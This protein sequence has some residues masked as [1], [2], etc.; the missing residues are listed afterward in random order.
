[1]REMLRGEL[2]RELR[3]RPRSALQALGED[4]ARGLRASRG[5]SLGGCYLSAIRSAMGSYS[6]SC[7]R[8]PS[9]S[10]TSMSERVDRPPLERE[11][12]RIVLIVN[13]QIDGVV[14]DGRRAI[15]RAVG[16]GAVA[17]LE[18][19]FELL[20]QRRLGG[21]E[22]PR[23]S[24]RRETAAAPAGGRSSS[25]ASRRPAS[26][27]RARTRRGPR[28]RA[29]ID[30]ASRAHRSRAALG[31]PEVA[32]Q[33]RERAPVLGGERLLRTCAA[34]S[35]RRPMSP[36]KREAL[37]GVEEPRRR[38]TACRSPSPA[39]RTG[40]CAAGR[41]S[42]AAAASCTRSARRSGPSRT[43]SRRASRAGPGEPRA[44][45]ARVDPRDGRGRFLGRLRSE[46]QSTQ[47]SLLPPPRCMETISACA[48]EAKR[49]RPPGMTR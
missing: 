10:A 1:M 48:S 33:N 41:G 29:A 46:S 3:R 35:P 32:L 34:H 43:D 31:A 42:R 23:E 4:A 28:A 26:C 12:A 14:P 16:D 17:D 45:G 30:R 44:G 2:I 27:R 22:A 21:G 6:V 5:S 37:L 18:Q 38:R 36:L 25:G 13:Q 8:V 24:P 47:M 49:A 11:R 39:T 15:A 19:P 7:G 9:D 20:P 40:D